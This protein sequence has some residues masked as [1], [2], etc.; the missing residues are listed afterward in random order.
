MEPVSVIQTVGFPIF[1]CILM[2]RQYQKEREHRRQERQ[3]WQQ[4]L[5]EQTEVLRD[6]KRH[7]E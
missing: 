6:V 5:E 7:V 2:F 4:A 1:V 3:T